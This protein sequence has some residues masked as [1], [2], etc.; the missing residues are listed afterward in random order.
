MANLYGANLSGT[1]L[2]G[3]DLSGAFLY[4]ASL[5]FAN[6]SGVDLRRT[7]LRAS[8]GWT[9]KQLAAAKT[10][11]GTIMPDGQVLRGRKTLSDVYP[12]DVDGPSF[13]DWLKK[14]GSGE[15]GRNLRGF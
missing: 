8:L 14:H 6:L 15:S 7:N 12:S 5:S 1:N 4:G 13:E 3:A 10:L 11:E 2:S 9:E